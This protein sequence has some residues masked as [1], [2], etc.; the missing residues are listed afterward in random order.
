MQHKSLE[1]SSRLPDT[2]FLKGKVMIVYSESKAVA[3]ILAVLGWWSEGESSTFSKVQARQLSEA[4][5]G[6]ESIKAWPSTGRSKLLIKHSFR[7][8]VDPANTGVCP[9]YGGVRLKKK[10][11]ENAA[12]H[13]TSFLVQGRLCSHI[14]K[15]DVK[16]SDNAL[17]KPVIQAFPLSTEKYRRTINPDDSGPSYALDKVFLT[18]TIRCSAKL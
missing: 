16:W 6:G 9:V 15:N 14:T 5:S 2:D 3:R 8:L 18:R 10:V 17:T 1:K 13:W 7:G 4:Y 11:I 12:W